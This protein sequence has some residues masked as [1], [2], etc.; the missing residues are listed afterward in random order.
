[1]HQKFSWEP[2]FAM[3]F[4]LCNARQYHMHLF[5]VSRVFHIFSTHALLLL[6]SCLVIQKKDDWEVFFLILN[7]IK[8]NDFLSLSFVFKSKVNSITSIKSLISELFKNIQNGLE[9]KSKECLQPLHS[10]WLIKEI[11]ILKKIR[12]YI[13]QFLSKRVCRNMISI[14]ILELLNKII[15]IH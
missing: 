1:M 11:F 14:C 13:I 3:T 10:L 4:Y 9:D 5:P 15:I 2:I 7:K 6:H 8:T 12:V